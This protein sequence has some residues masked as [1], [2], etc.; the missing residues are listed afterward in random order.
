[1][2]LKI[3]DN[4]KRL[5]KNKGMT[6]EQLAELL[7]ISCA[8]VSKWESSD[9][10]PDITIIMPLAR[11][12]DVSIDELMGYNS[13]KVE[14]EIEK[15]IIDY[16]QLQAE[17]K[18]QEATELIKLARKEY[19]NDYRVMSLYIWDLA[20]GSADNSQETLNVYHDEFL[21]ICDCILGGCT[22]E[23]LRLETITMKAK[24]LHA[25]GDTEAALELLAQFPSWY[26]SSG[27]KI[28]QLFAKDTPEFRYYVK[29]NLYELSDFAADKAVKVIF[30]DD[31]ITLDEK[32]AKTE[33]LGDMISA[34]YDKSGEAV[35]A[36][37]LKSLWGRLANDLTFRGG[38]TV[39]II[40]ITE[41]QLRATKFV[42]E[43][44]MTDA[45]LFDCFSK[46]NGTDNLLNWTLNYF[47]TCDNKALARLRD[48]PEYMAMLDK[49]M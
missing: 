43:I 40:R 33:M 19:P 5:R 46:P 29:C 32:V 12:F 17:G 39:D 45:A 16:R 20:G 18:Y 3:G 42:T 2:E 49:F 30:F 47:R 31:T 15:M 9:T 28:E 35:F 27:Q 22:D 44:S 34:L 23:S 38:K 1:M 21:Q 4:I 26:Q 41:K 36:V 11:V 48:N 14:A 8:A 13:A 10:Y 6:Q 7:N 24:L 37:I 25:A